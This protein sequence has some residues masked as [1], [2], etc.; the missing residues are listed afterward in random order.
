[1]KYAQ[2]LVRDLLWAVN[3]PSLLES[4]SSHRCHT[5]T[6][7]LHEQD[8]QVAHLVDF[9]GKKKIHSLGKYFE[10]LISYWLHHLRQVEVLRESF[11][12]REQKR[13]VGEIDFIFIDEQGRT[14]HWE[15][16]VKFYLFS[17]EA[18]GLSSHYLG[19]NAVDT[20]DRKIER[21]F[22]HQLPRSEKVFPDV[23]LREVF[24]KG[25]IFYPI[26]PHIE[27]KN[28]ASL[29][30]SHL[31]GSWLRHAQL[32]L[33]ENDRGWG[34]QDVRYMVLKKP[35]WLA[36][37]KASSTT[38]GLM[39][40]CEFTDSMDQH[41]SGSRGCPLVVQLN[42]DGERYVEARRLFVV[43]DRWPRMM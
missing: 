9:M 18:H 36:E 20:L 39:S 40:F 37:I 12:I 34:H 32:G 42:L 4:T 8:I 22:E 2:Q 16:A 30:S 19:P 15:I 41:F 31:S 11:A 14:V 3:S 24:V 28:H 29:S 1:M 23:E 10:G 21:L 6:S 25:R 5:E 17:P 33:L 7:G 13:T 26:L 38:D 35:H 43:P 27:L